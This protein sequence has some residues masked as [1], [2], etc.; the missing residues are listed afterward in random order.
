MLEERLTCPSLA[1][2][3]GEQIYTPITLKLI[4]INFTKTT[5]ADLI[6]I[7]K[8]K[9][10]ATTLRLKMIIELKKHWFSATSNQRR[11]FESFVNKIQS[12]GFDLETCAPAVTCVQWQSLDW[13]LKEVGKV[14]FA[15]LRHNYKEIL[16]KLVQISEQ[17]YFDWL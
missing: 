15:G 2:R 8:P 4:V 5:T 6:G 9:I 12:F 17:G 10:T 14:L 11:T 3:I 16:C 7:F 1:E 13:G